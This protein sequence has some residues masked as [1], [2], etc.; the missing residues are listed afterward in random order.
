MKLEWQQLNQSILESSPPEI[1]KSIDQLINGSTFTSKLS[2]YLSEKF[3]K[4]IND[5]Q[6]NVS[7]HL[8][9]LIRRR[10]NLMK[11]VIVYSQKAVESI[12]CEDS[13]NLIDGY[14][15]PPLP[16]PRLGDFE[17]IA[18]I[19]R[20][21]FGS[22]FL[23]SRKQTGDIYALKA[24]LTDTFHADDNFLDTERE[25]MCRA[26]HPSI[27]SL[28]WS[29]RA[30][31]TIFFVMNFA[32]GGDLFSLL[33]S[34]GNLEEDIAIFYLAE[35]I[36]AVDYL[37]SLGV[38]H[39]DLKPANT[40]LSTTGH[41]QLTDF[42]LSKVGAE[43]RE[44][45]R[46]FLFRFSSQNTTNLQ[47]NENLNKRIIGTPYYIAPESLLK[48]EYSNA[49]DWWSVGVIAYELVIGEPPFMG[50]NESQIFSNIVKGEFSWP[51]DVEI[52][53]EYKQF[54]NKLLQL[55]P[56]TRPEINELKDSKIFKNINFDSIYN[57]EAPFIPELKDIT[58]LSYFANAYKNINISTNDFEELRTETK[59][60][61]KPD[62]WCCTNIAAL[63]EKNKEVLREMKKKS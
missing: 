50:D 21:A 41:L 46:S 12:D 55:N 17:I 24:I 8:S 61:D 63:S 52:S 30:G 31:S 53:D 23:C 57:S 54:V 15:M 19:S 1:K 56:E 26:N 2:L 16:P 7:P 22:V 59:N 60:R 35:L 27:V 11:K 48:G 4:S 29:F 39:C 5:G 42:G 14:L 3:I 51:N 45:K 58:D 62:E 9:D 10:H 13:P 28:Y 43:Q 44:F 20:G 6:I 34:V 18:P 49:T 32:C 40:L 38:V 25:I 33:E 47:H 36:I 37:H